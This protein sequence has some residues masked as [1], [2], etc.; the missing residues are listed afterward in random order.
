[1]TKGATADGKLPVP[2]P[3]AE[4][5]P[6]TAMLGRPSEDFRHE[7]DLAGRQGWLENMINQIPDYLYAKDLQ[8]RFLFANQAVVF[9][10][11]LSH[12]KD[13]VGRTDFD[14]LPS[15]IVQIAADVERHVAETGQP[16]FG[17]EELAFRGDRERWLMITRVPLRDASGKIVGTIG[18]SRDITEQKSAERRMRSQSYL[19]EMIARGTPLSDFLENLA[20]MIEGFADGVHAALFTIAPDTGE[21]RL[22]AAPSLNEEYRRHVNATLIRTV[23]TDL[24][25]TAAALKLVF[26]QAGISELDHQCHCSAI[27]DVDGQVEGVLAVY[28]SAGTRYQPGFSDFVSIAV[29]MAGIAISRHRAEARIGFLA[30]HDP[31]TGMANRALLDRKLTLAMQTA[32]SLGSEVALAFLDLDNFKLV[33]DSLGHSVGDQLLKTVAERICELIID[34]GSLA[35]I[36]GDEFV[37]ILEQTD[38]NGC[39]GR[40]SAIKEAVA[41]P[42]AL[43]GIELRATCSIGVA[44]YPSHGKTAEDLLASAD[45]AM[46]RAKELGRDGIAI[47]TPE[48]TATVRRK[49][50]RTD[51]LRQ[52]LLRDE[53]VLHYQ[54]QVDVQTGSIVA[55]EALVRWNHPGEGLVYPGDF[56][57]L[58]EETGHIVPIG[59]WVLQRAC[60]QAKAWQ[61]HG[62][63]PIRICVNVSARQF[64]EKRLIETVANALSESGLDPTWLELEITES[65]IMKDLASSI[66]RMH[67]LEQLGVK[68]AVDDFGT[69]YSSLSALKR[70]PLSRLKIDRSFIADIPHDADDMAITA[71]IISL[72][73]KLDLEVIAEGV[74]T[75]EQARFLVDSGCN[76][77]QGYLYSRPVEEERF[78]CML[79][80]NGRIHPLLPL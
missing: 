63:P 62:L 45:M 51:E 49:L 20:R 11:G 31:L 40:L 18:A 15:H 55:A 4:Q 9:N 78:H 68:L 56:I 16:H 38:I 26:D 28:S 52:A 25:A 37:I 24:T 71:A 47:F 33:N 6:N 32:D 53:F 29:H 58:A 65:L 80:N 12:L 14:F 34:Q 72:A 77:I 79:E 10:N 21:L 19:L 3:A 13:L 57:A 5:A 2:I 36:G 76:E 30:D 46:Y 67:E 60:K 27:S 8:G 22:V 42:I 64:Q 17:S 43:N 75:K 74:E 44:S 66:A 23:P 54:P 41:R 59:E 7:A 61:D 35:R 50:S 69:G 70:F 1:M 73:Q 48:M 39:L